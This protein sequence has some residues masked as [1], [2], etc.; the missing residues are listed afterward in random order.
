[1]ALEL[2]LGPLI[3]WG[4]WHFYLYHSL[5][6]GS[7]LF[8]SQQQERVEPSLRPSYRELNQTHN[9]EEQQLPAPVKV[10]VV[11]AVV[12]TSG[13]IFVIVVVGGGVTKIVVAMVAASTSLL[14]SSSLGV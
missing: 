10:I 5:A 9:L 2:T 14:V 7:V 4:L 12:A 3:P 13:I 8:L 11:A 1:M 6:T